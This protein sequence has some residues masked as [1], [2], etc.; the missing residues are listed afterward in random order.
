MKTLIL[1]RHGEAQNFT[2]DYNR[3]LFPFVKDKINT[4]ALMLKGKNINIDKFFVSSSLR[5]KQT[6][7]LLIKGLKEDKN[8][9]TLTKELYLPSLNELEL[10]IQLNGE[11][12][13]SIMIIGHNPSLSELASY[14]TGKNILFDTLQ[15]VALKIDLKDWSDLLPNCA[16]ILF[17]L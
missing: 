5:T 16:S 2:S 1:L 9:L 10:F 12:Y 13:Q 8:K 6:A 7:Q 3:E 14:L 17:T 15:G 11:D 4:L